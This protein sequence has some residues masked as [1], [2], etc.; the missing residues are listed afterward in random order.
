MNSQGSKTFLFRVR[1]FWDHLG[2]K[3]VL[4]LLFNL[5]SDHSESVDLKKSHAAAFSSMMTAQQAW[6]VSVEHSM[7]V[8]SHCT[9]KKPAPPPSP[10]GPPPSPPGPAPRNCTFQQNFG[11]FGGDQRL[12]SV[13]SKEDCCAL[14]IADSACTVAVFDAAKSK[15]HIKDETKDG[16]TKHDFWTCRARPKARD[17]Q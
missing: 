9:G 12:N 5:T 10:P 1:L 6:I 13:E 8:E 14:C 17:A 11:G 16:Y 4:P 2:S 15:C 3:G 7:A